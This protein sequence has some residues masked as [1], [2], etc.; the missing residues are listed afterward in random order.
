MRWRLRHIAHK[1][2]EPALG[3]IRPTSVELL[4]RVINYAELPEELFTLMLDTQN[5]G[6]IRHILINGDWFLPGEKA[7]LYSILGIQNNSSLQLM[8][9][10]LSL[11]SESVHEGRNIRFRLQII[12]LYGYRCFLC[13]I[14]M[15]LPSGI[16]LVEAAHIH[17]FSKSRNDDIQ[18]GIAL[19]RNHHWAFDNGLWTLSDYFKVIVANGKFLDEAPNQMPLGEYHNR[20][21]DLSYIVEEHRPSKTNLI[22]YRTY[23]FVG[24]TQ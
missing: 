20:Y 5:R 19:C 10:D 17:Q 18:N 7:K 12:P 11:K 14:K 4:N 21:I 9:D 3:S 8:N 22:W 24:D 13:G 1:G 23:T 15:L 2:L 16:T 6:A